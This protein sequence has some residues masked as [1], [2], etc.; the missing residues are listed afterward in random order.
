ML[1]D[2]QIQIITNLLIDNGLIF[3][4]ANKTFLINDPDFCV[5]I[6]LI[7]DYCYDLYIDTINNETDIEFVLN[8]I[9]SL[10][11]KI[12]KYREFYASFDKMQFGY[13]MY[14]FMNSFFDKTN[15]AFIEFLNTL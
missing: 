15:E 2:K 6:K 13:D 5:Q 3:N 7:K 4:E 9:T 12:A 11:N 8:N 14:I 1:T 10:L